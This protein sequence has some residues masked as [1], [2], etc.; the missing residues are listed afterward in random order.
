VVTSTALTLVLL[1]V[2]YVWTEGGFRSKTPASQDQ[3]T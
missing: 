3:K 1:P 2:F